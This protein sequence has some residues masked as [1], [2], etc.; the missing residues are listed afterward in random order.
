[1]GRQMGSRKLRQIIERDGGE[2]VCHYCGHPIIPQDTPPCDDRYFTVVA[3]NTEGLVTRFD[4]YHCWYGD[5]FYMY[6]L[7]P[8]VRLGEVDH[9]TPQS[10][11]GRHTLDNLVAACKSCNAQKRN[12]TAEEYAAWLAE[13]TS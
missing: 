12:K 11:G 3:T 2:W 7:N 4:C 13:H 8:G 1:M 6:T 10:R 5:T 9:L